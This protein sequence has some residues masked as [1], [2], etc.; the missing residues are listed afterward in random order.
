MTATAVAVVIVMAL[1][2]SGNGQ[3][4]VGGFVS[5]ITAMLMLLAPL[6][7]L[8]EINGPLQRGMAAAEEVYNLIDKTTERTTGE[9]LTR[10]RPARSISLMS[11]SPIPAMSSWRSR[12]STCRSR[13]ARPSPSWAC[14][15]AANPRW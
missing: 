8:A 6:K 13:P 4:T 10:A 12:T 9:A 14:P 3:I 15:A 2:Q 7:Q 11:A 1:I 5:F